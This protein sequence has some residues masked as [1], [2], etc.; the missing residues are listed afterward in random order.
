MTP[1]AAWLC[2]VTMNCLV[3]VA[4]QVLKVIRLLVANETSQLG[5]THSEKFCAEGSVSEARQISQEVNRHET[6]YLHARVPALRSQ[7]GE[8]GHGWDQYPSQAG[9]RHHSGIFCAQKWLCET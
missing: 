7:A 8:E 3:P 2:H 9:R 4:S 1:R 6:T 5:R